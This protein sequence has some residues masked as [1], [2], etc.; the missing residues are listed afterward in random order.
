[1]I[2]DKSVSFVFKHF[3]FVLEI[4]T[5]CRAQAQMMSEMFQQRKVCDS[6]ACLRG[7]VEDPRAHTMLTQINIAAYQL[8]SHERLQ[9]PSKPAGC[10]INMLPSEKLMKRVGS[11]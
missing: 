8:S 2:I 6:F 3:D 11:I 4:L 7:E 5:N 1:M 9:L 10:I